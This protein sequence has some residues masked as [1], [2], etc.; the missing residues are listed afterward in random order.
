MTSK[1]PQ[2]EG[3]TLLGCSSILICLMNIVPLGKLLLLVVVRIKWI[4]HVKH[5]EWSI[6]N[7]IHVSNDKDNDDIN[8][9]WRASLHCPWQRVCVIMLPFLKLGNHPSLPCSPLVPFLLATS[10]LEAHCSGGKDGHIQGLWESWVCPSL[11]P[12]FYLLVTLKL[13][14]ASSVSPS[15][16]CDQDTI[17]H[18]LY[19]STVGRKSL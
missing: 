3:H 14:L 7:L 19:F 9:V 13:L 12:G 6:I 15:S 4:I 16:E 10:Y 5:L 11:W 8:K 18:L 1:I 2:S 17:N